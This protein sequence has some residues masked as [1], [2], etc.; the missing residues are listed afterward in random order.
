M[1]F[2][3]L[4]GA[5]LLLA[6]TYGDDEKPP[7][8]RARKVDFEIHEREH[9]CG[10]VLAITK[11]SILINDERKGPLSFPFHDRLAAGGV[12]KKVCAATAYLVSD[13]KVGDIVI[14]G[15]MTENKQVFCVDLSIRERP[16]GLVPPCQLSEK[17]CPYH[18]C[19]NAEIAFRDKGTPIPEHLKPVIPTV[20]KPK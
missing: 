14:S 19:R 10:T 9:S 6:P 16:D 15:L 11:T 20:N 5:L 18:E 8:A 13:I 4:F 7:G 3:C 2:A 1:R 17:K 12:H